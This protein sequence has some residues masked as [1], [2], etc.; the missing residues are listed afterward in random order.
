[1]AIKG[2]LSL[3][4]FNCRGVK[5]SLKEVS[6]MCNIFDI[7]LI[8]EHWLLPN[9]ISMLSNIDPNFISVGQSAV[10]TSNNIL[11]GRPYGGTAI[12]YNKLLCPYVS[13]VASS[14]PR[15]TAICLNSKIGPILIACVYMPTDYGDDDCIED[16][17]EICS[18][19]SALHTVCDAVQLIVAGDFNCQPGSRFYKYFQTFVNDNN[20]TMSDLE[21]IQCVYL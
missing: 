17:I 15:L 5:S 14:N 7:I 2:N 4:T 6:M 16:Y 18:E 1:M 11:I 9:E 19:I 20:L 21:T 8:Q 12:I 10:D 3:C 13:F